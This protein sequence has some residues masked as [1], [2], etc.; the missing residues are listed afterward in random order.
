MSGD[1]TLRRP[2]DMVWQDAHY[3]SVITSLGLQ[4]LSSKERRESLLNMKTT[5]LVAKLPAFMH[6]SPTVDGSFIKEEITIGN[7]KDPGYRRGK[8]DWCKS[9]FVGDAAHDVCNLAS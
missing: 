2:R 9:I 3:Q 5:D 1:P 8:P 6:W 7:L 4:S